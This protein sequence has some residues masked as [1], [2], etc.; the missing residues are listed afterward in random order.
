[1]LEKEG[2][3]V[4]DRPAKSKR[5]KVRK[6]TANAFQG[7]PRNKRGKGDMERRELMRLPG[8]TGP[9]SQRKEKTGP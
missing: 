3:K 9:V 1:M 7:N 6:I 4:K 8:K 5:K 2:E